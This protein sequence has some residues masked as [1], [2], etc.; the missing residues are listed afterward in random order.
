M[1]SAAPPVLGDLERQP[2]FMGGELCQ[3][4][5]GSL[6]VALTMLWDCHAAY[7]TWQDANPGLP[8]PACSHL[9][10]E[11]PALGDVLRVVHRIPSRYAGV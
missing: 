9:G 11:E 4:T 5:D 7:R 8:D 10:C 3:A 1:I 2:G 6:L